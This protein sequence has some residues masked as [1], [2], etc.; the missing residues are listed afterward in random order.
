MD[1][2]INRRLNLTIPITD[3]NP[4]A[5]KRRIIAWVH[6]MPVTSETL[7]TFCLELGKVY[8]AI[9]AEGLHHFAGPQIAAKLLKRVAQQLK[10]WEEVDKGLIGEIRRMTNIL[11]IGKQGWE[12]LTYDLAMERKVLTSEDVSVVENLLVFF[13]VVCANIPR[14]DR[15]EY[16]DWAL[17]RWSARIESFS[18]MEFQRSLP[19]L[20][21]VENTG[22]N[23]A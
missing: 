5:K 19:T 12:P 13:T 22:G 7:D 3:E 11:V 1:V 6:S 4:D 9:T 14:L 8:G 23:A 2:K 10:T 16:L 18:L 17:S 21:P 15:A 20:T